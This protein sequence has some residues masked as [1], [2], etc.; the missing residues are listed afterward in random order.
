VKLVIVL[1]DTRPLGIFGLGI[2]NF[3]GS[4]PMS[5]SS[6]FLDGFLS[7]SITW[8]VEDAFTTFLL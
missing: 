8:I 7:I 2:M 6:A 5:I 3:M 4:M 1:L